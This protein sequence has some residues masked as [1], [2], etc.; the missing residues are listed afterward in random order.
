MTKLNQIKEQAAA[1]LSKIAIWSNRSSEKCGLEGS[2]LSEECQVSKVKC[3]RF[4]ASSRSEH[5]RDHRE[6]NHQLRLVLGLIELVRK[7]VL[8]GLSSS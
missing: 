4:N 3:T 1:E 7:A 2:R 8:K 6:R 5:R